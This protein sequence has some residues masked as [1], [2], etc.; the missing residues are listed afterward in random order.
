MAVRCHSRDSFLPKLFGRRNGLRFRVS[1]EWFFVFLQLSNRRY[2]DIERDSLDLSSLTSMST[3]GLSSKS[4]A[5]PIVSRAYI[6][7]QSHTSDHD[8]GVIRTGTPRHKSKQTLILPDLYHWQWAWSRSPPSRRSCT[9]QKPGLALSLMRSL[10]NSPA[11]HRHSYH[12]LA[13]SHADSRCTCTER[14]CIHTAPFAPPVTLGSATGISNTSNTSIWRSRD[15]RCVHTRGAVPCYYAVREIARGRS[16]EGY[17][18]PVGVLVFVPSFSGTIVQVR[19]PLLRFE[20]S[21]S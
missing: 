2:A 18:M 8:D 16:D 6:S 14:C 17:K 21:N 19:S 7:C 13:R 11:P 20:W 9:T 10:P 3:N 1:G 15:L 12:N 5:A 4:S